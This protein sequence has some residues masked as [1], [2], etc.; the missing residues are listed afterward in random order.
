MNS[1]SDILPSDNHD[2]RHRALTIGVAW[3][4]VGD[5]RAVLAAGEA[6][7]FV[8]EVLVSPMNVTTGDAARVAA[9]G[10]T[11]VRVLPPG[12]T[13]IYSAW[14]KL[15]AA[16][17]TSHIAFHGVDDLVV[18]DPA[19]AAA[20]ADLGADEMLVA[21]IQLATPGGVPTAIYHHRETDPPALSLGR[22]ANPAC[23]EVCWPV[24]QLRAVGGLDERFRIAGDV[25]LYFRVRPKV[26]RV[27]IEA[28]LLVMRDGGVSVS[29]KH[30]AT[31]WAENRHIARSYGQTVPIGNR[32][33]SGC[34]LQGR[35]WLYRIGGEHFA[36]TLTDGMRALFGKTR[37]YSL[38]DSG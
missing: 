12:D 25:D 18:P 21:S 35:G 6:A 31:V 2:P 3:N 27:D 8:A 30:S 17:R 4:G 14:N 33:L 1:G 5:P 36:D 19:I 10:L 15:V 32:L 37:R 26:R 23:P 34:F 11:K 20:L 29:A 13:G 9:V 24:S 28:V 38:R 16:C 7:G 22:H